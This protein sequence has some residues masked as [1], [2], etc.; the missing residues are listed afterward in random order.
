MRRDFEDPSDT[1]GFY[2]PEPEAQQHYK[3]IIFDVDGT[4]VET[5]SGATFREQADDWQWLP[6]RVERLKALRKEGVRLA[7]ATN[8]GG[9]AFGYLAQADIL[10]ELFVLCGEGGIAVGGMNICYYHPNATLAHFCGDNYRRKPEPGMLFD[11]MADFE[12]GL[13]DTLFVG[14]MPDDQEAARRAG[15]DFQ[16][17][18]DFFGDGDANGNT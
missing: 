5:R 2:E 18:K 17:A 15:C 9:V 13:L 7:I 4:L 16:W 12:L 8:Q 11:A 6:G 3:L 10:H 1:R 14:D